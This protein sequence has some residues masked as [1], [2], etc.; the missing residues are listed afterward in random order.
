MG[1]TPQLRGLLFAVEINHEHMNL[2]VQIN[3]SIVQA[4]MGATPQS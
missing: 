3:S 4:E 1:A 2:D